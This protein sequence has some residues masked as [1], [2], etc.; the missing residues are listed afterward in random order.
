MF[1]K[2]IAAALL[3]LSA[4]AASATVIVLQPGS[5]GKDAAINNGG[6]SNV[7]SGSQGHL[8]INYGTPNQFGLIEF[9]LA[10]YAGQSVVSATLSLYAQMN[11]NA[12]QSYSL[13]TNTAAWDESTVKWSN[14]PTFSAP[15]ASI[16]TSAG[17][18]W[19]SFDVTGAV[20][21]WLGGSANYGFRLSETNGYVYFASSDNANAL[22]RPTL[23]FDTVVAPVPEPASM[24]LFAVALLG[25]G[26]LSRRR[27]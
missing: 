23:T 24:A 9:D 14:A 5:E 17:A 18:Q 22:L 1:S 15:F 27:K 20:N 7:S 2:F 19:Y 8:T 25:A 3:A 11:T 21:G 12:G 16:V 10:A 4:T 26:A 13:A 6:A